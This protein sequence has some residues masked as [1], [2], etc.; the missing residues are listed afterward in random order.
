MKFISS[1]FY[2]L[3]KI[4]TLFS[5]PKTK[6]ALLYFFLITFNN[7]VAN[8]FI[9]NNTHNKWYVSYCLEKIAQV[10]ITTTILLHPLIEEQLPPSYK[11]PFTFLSTTLIIGYCAHIC[12]NSEKNSAK[13]KSIVIN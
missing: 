3:E 2:T 13:L 8:P 1:F 11:A 5:Q 9:K 6:S 10:S 7:I 12:K 4:L